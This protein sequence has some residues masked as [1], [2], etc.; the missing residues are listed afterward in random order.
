MSSG[1]SLDTSGPVPDYWSVEP[2]CSDTWLIKT[3]GCTSYLV[4]GDERGLV[5]DTGFDTK[6][7][8]AYAQSMTD[9]PVSWVANTHG[10]FDHTAGNGWFDLAYMSAEAAKIANV[11]YPSKAKYTYPLDYPIEIVGDGDS[12]DLG[13]RELEVIEI[14]AHAPSSVAYLD[15]KQRIL[16]SG[17][18]VAPFVMLYWQQD[19]PQPTIEQYA[20]NMEKLLARRSEFDHVCWGHG[21]GLMDASLVEHCH[22]NALQILSGVEGAPM[23]LGDDH[24]EDFV[25][26]KVEFKRVSDYK[27]SHIGYDVRYVFDRT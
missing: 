18:E 15:K 9:K 17:D 26:L 6:N 4:T 22:Q 7:V 27:D 10:H 13:G 19:E 3:D 8:Q 12:I 2:L 25:M 16:F 14:P 20:K 5:I 1:N 21:E 23:D 24:P 11:P